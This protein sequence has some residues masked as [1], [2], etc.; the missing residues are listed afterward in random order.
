MGSEGGNLTLPNS[1][2][3]AHYA[4]GFHSYSKREFPERRPYLFDLDV[5][6]LEPDVMVEP[7]WTDY[8]EGRDPVFEAVVARIRQ[9][10]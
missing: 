2:L 3:T 4:N 10:H 6:S 9:S 5:D 1:G 8:I 7:S